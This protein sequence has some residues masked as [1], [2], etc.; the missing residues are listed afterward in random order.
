MKSH[1]FRK[2][3]AENQCTAMRDEKPQRCFYNCSH[4][5][6]R[7]EVKSER[8]RRLGNSAPVNRE[9]VKIEASSK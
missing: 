4:P 8:E 1:A 7:N 2:N 5:A 9:A 3:G 6:D